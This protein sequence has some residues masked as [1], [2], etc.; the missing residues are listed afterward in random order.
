MLVAV[1]MGCN[2]SNGGGNVEYGYIEYAGTKHAITDAYRTEMTG[3]WG[4]TFIHLITKDHIE[5]VLEI[6]NFLTPDNGVYSQEQYDYASEYEDEILR[7]L[8]T[9]EEHTPTGFTPKV[10]PTGTVKIKSRSGNEYDLTA[11]GVTVE[12]K[13]VDIAFKGTIVLETGM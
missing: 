2:S 5:V 8:V 7:Y 3:N 12:N 1:F 6:A 11:S 10:C 13:S 9:V 4:A